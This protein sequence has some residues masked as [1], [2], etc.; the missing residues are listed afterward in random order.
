MFR[1][2]SLVATLITVTLCAGL[3]VAG[4][5]TANAGAATTVSRN[6]GNHKHRHGR[7]HRHHRPHHRHRHNKNR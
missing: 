7:H 3:I 1:K 4:S 2:L 6:Y 5:T